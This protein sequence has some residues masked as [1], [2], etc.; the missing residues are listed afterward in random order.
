MTVNL[1][2]Y[3]YDFLSESEH[4]DIFDE[5]NIYEVRKYDID[6]GKTETVFSTK[7]NS[8]ISAMFIGYDYLYY[9]KDGKEHVLR[10]LTTGREYCLS[11][12]DVKMPWVIF[13]DGLLFIDDSKI[14]LWRYGTDI[15]EETGKISNIPDGRRL[16]IECITDRWVYAHLLSDEDEI[17]VYCPKNDFLKGKAE[18]REYEIE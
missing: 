1:K 14:E 7:T 15:L 18:W 13:T 6:T 10:S 4:Q 17:R 11:M 2:E 9:C 3:D 12:E 16:S 8:A 5:S